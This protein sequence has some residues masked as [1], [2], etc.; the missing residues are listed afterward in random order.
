MAR[1]FPP[2]ATSSSLIEPDEFREEWKTWGTDL[3]WPGHFYP[4]KA[5]PGTRKLLDAIRNE[6]KTA[7]E[8]IIAT[9]CDRE[10]QLIGDEILDYIK[11]KGKRLRCIFNAEDATSLKKAFSELKPN[12]QFAGLYASGQA[13]EQ[14]DQTVNLSLTRAAT[15]TMKNPG[16]KGAIG[17]G[18][19]KTPVLAIVCRREQEILEFKPQDL[20]EIDATVRTGATELL[21]TCARMPESLVK[22]EDGPDEDDDDL[23]ADEEALAAA[24][25]LRGRIQKR[26]IADGLCKAVQGHKGPLASEYSKRKQGPPK[27][28]D[29]TALQSTASARFRLV[30]RPHAGSG[31]ETLFRKN[32]HH[33]SPGPSPNIFRKPT[34]QTSRSSFRR[35]SG[36]R[37]TAS[38]PTCSESRCRARASPATSRT[39]ASTAAR[40]TPSSRM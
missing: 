32:P 4:K 22:E 39:P 30:R 2:R 20:Y 28:F 15:V 21:L 9:D 13:R 14:A 3:L 35:C 26:Q 10:G 27:L 24:Q 25:P 29:L 18:R 6:A 5:S 8:V 23:E 40:I 34:L 7:D 31:P 33:L 19:V 16:G 37:S 11:F 38:T 12:E 1:C 36:S 17:I